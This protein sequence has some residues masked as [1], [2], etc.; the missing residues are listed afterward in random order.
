MLVRC[1]YRHTQATYSLLLRRIAATRRAIPENHAIFYTKY[2]HDYI[3]P[4][5]KT[6]GEEQLR[7][8]PIEF[9]SSNP[10]E[11]IGMDGLKVNYAKI[12]AVEHDIKA[13][14]IGRI[15]S[16]SMPYLYADF[17]ATWAN[18]KSAVNL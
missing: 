11:E 7:L 1:S 9:I 12:Y 15:R 6:G 13:V 16:S 10:R 18:K 8:H 3:N 5:P 17:N 4:H 14:F 2:S